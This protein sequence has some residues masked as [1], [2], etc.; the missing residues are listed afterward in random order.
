MQCDSK[1]HAVFGGVRGNIT[2]L[3]GAQSQNCL[4]VQTKQAEAY[5]MADVLLVWLDWDKRRRSIHNFI[6]RDWSIFS[7][8]RHTSLSS[9]IGL[10]RQVSFAWK[11]HCFRQ[12]WSLVFV[13]F[14]GLT[15][16]FLL[17]QSFKMCV[18]E[19]TSL[20]LYLNLPL[21]IKNK[22]LKWS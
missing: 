12:I 17:L 22:S 10:H 8:Y 18:G 5:A 16:S 15:Y 19:R 20:Y 1:P 21:L 13:S 3:L 6:L 9:F 4:S 11:C 14:I 2:G 7:I